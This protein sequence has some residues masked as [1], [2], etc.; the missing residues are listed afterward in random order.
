MAESQ[1][2]NVSAPNRSFPSMLPATPATSS[3]GTEVEGCKHRDCQK[4]NTAAIVGGI[5]GGI[6]VVCVL[7][8]VFFYRRFRYQKKLNQF[9]KEHQLL[10]QTPPDSLLASTFVRP[11]RHGAASPP[12]GGRCSPVS[13]TTTR[14]TSH[15]ALGFDGTMQKNSHYPSVV[16][17]PSSDSVSLPHEPALRAQHGYGANPS[18]L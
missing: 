13:P 4:N 3:S 5:A 15:V 18:N 10:H 6:A 7:V 14:R 17:S 9:H 12:L 1:S 8:A 11:N 16:S 2:F